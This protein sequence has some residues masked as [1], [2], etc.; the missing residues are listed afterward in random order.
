MTL[1]EFYGFLREKGALEGFMRNL[2][3][4]DCKP[5]TT[6]DD[7]DVRIAEMLRSKASPVA[8]AFLWRETS[9]GLSYWHNLNAAVRLIIRENFDDEKKIKGVI[10]E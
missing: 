7:I 10:D 2:T 8:A 6:I 1:D 5:N 9:E 4:L 3:L